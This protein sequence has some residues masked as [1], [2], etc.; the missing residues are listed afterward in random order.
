MEIAPPHLLFLG[1]AADQLAAKTAEGLARWRLG[2]C[3]G[4]LRLPGCAADCGLP[5]LTLEAGREAGARSLVVGVAN[6][7]GT[8]AESWLPT[9]LRALELGYDIAAGLHDRLSDRP[10][11]AEAAR[12]HGRRLIDIR[13]A[14]RRFPVAS[15]RPR[16]GRRLLTV[17][18]DCSVGKMV[19]A[20][21][22]TAALKDRG[23]R[24]TFRAT[25]QTGILIAGG[26]VPVDALPGD[27]IAGAA[28]WLTP[29]NDPDHW[30]IVEGQ[31]S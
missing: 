5:D 21:A 20:L 18:T 28:E 22:L 6:R 31:G 26:G 25:G 19:T 29:A 12:R 23:A 24:A 13:H 17:G 16:P 4:Q 1:D 9:L 10:E 30:D 8:L 27:F 2:D 7:G 15:G 11:L 14:D 3:A